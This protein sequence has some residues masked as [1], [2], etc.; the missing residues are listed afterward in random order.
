MRESHLTLVVS[1]LEKDLLER[2]HGIRGVEVVG[3]VQPVVTSVPPFSARRDLVFVGYFVHRPNVDAVLWFVRESWPLVRRQ[4]PDVRLHVIGRDPPAEVVALASD[5]I[6]V[7][8]QVPQLEALLDSARVMVAPLRY[9]A[10]VKGKITQALSRGLPVVATPV[11]VEGIGLRDGEEVLV[12]DGPAE[13]ATS[14][15]RLYTDA[16][17][18]ERLSQG[19]LAHAREHLSVEAVGRRV[20]SLLERAGLRGDNV[21]AVS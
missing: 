15:T 17:L 18:W 21:G 6:H 11:G 4:L 1:S 10:G 3:I 8:G 2:E 12:A 13:F 16:A 7:H 5:M 14:V 19:A 20:D 9:G